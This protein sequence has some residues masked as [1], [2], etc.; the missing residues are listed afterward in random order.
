[1]KNSGKK[2]T[3][4]D[5]TR[6]LLVGASLSKGQWSKGDTKKIQKIKKVPSVVKHRKRVDIKATLTNQCCM[7]SFIHPNT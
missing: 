4:R 6:V 3:M 5:I 7:K 2:F 1:M